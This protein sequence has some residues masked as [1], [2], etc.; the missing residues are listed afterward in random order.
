MSTIKNA[1]SKIDQSE[2]SAAEQK[3]A[4]RALEELGKA[5]AEIFVRD[6]QTGLRAAGEEK[7]NKTIPVS[8]MLSSKK[9]IRA[10]SSSENANIGNVVT[11]ALSS[12]LNGKKENIING[13][14]NLITGALTVFLG[15]GSASSDAI[16]MYYIAIDGLT[17]VRIDVKAWYCTVTAT[18]IKTKMER[19]VTV[20][21]TKSVIDITRIDLAT[22][23]YL[24]QSQFDANRMTPQE[25][26]AVIEEAANI[27][28]TFVEKAIRNG[29]VG[30]QR[31]TPYKDK[32]KYSRSL[33]EV[34]KVKEPAEA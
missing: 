31:D 25:L 2:A 23:L 5:K 30:Q 17:P 14:G 7:N 29:E 22:F 26:K 11:G 6:I 24:Y 34:R 15:E 4:L 16:E 20:V 3:E 1:I 8:C 28:N 33:G 10:F 18:S 13:A 12:F 9:E 32:E 19:V 27:Y 21:A